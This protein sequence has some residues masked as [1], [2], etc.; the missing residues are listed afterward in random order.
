MGHGK[1]TLVS[2]LHSN[3]TSVV[4][5]EARKTDDKDCSTVSPQPAPIKRRGAVKL[6]R[7]KSG[8]SEAENPPTSLRE[9]R[10]KKAPHVPPKMPSEP[11]PKSTP[12]TILSGSPVKSISHPKPKSVTPK[13]KPAQ[14]PKPPLPPKDTV[15]EVNPTLPPREPVHHSKPFPLPRSTAPSSNPPVPP[16]GLDPTPSSQPAA[17][18]P[19]SNFGPPLPPKSTSP[20]SSTHKRPKA[21]IKPSLPPKILDAK[22]KILRKKKTVR[23]GPDAILQQVVS[24]GDLEEL[25]EMVQ[26]QGDHIINSCDSNGE[27]LVVRAIT[28]KQL[29][30]LQYLISAGVDLTTTNDDGWTALHA[31][32][33]LDD[34]E[35][36]KAIL[37]TVNPVLT[38]IRSLNNLRPMDIA[39]SMQ[40]AKIL[41]T[42]DLEA[43]QSQ[44]EEDTDGISFNN[45]LT[46]ALFGCSDEETSLISCLLMKSVEDAKRFCRAKEKHLDYSLLHYA[47]IKNYVKL[48]YVLLKRHLVD[49]DSKDYT[50]QTPL[51]YAAKKAHSDMILLLKQFGA[52]ITC[53]DIKGQTP[54]FL[55]TPFHCTWLS[56]L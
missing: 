34:K 23:F 48:G 49:I 45:K 42:A 8:L 41:L 25:K 52:D 3:K 14:S 9:E 32:V 7:S 21:I 13:R 33:V 37:R 16:K 5:F 50:K 36:T 26:R 17:K 6:S 53:T 30:V 12:H 54:A 55:A 56:T 4:E 10:A 11:S 24:D 1:D 47:V 29:E 35:Y 2:E 46:L 27:P 44:L 31:A 28:Y 22:P 15:N 40:M 43:L 19:H 20:E 18:S 39:R 51:H 38:T